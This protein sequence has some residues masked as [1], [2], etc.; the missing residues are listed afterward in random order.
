MNLTA[1]QLAVIRMTLQ[2]V[3]DNRSILDLTTAELE[4]LTLTRNII[5]EY[6]VSAEIKEIN[7]ASQDRRR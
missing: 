1:R 6:E 3:I 4:E 7:N 2:Y 5:S